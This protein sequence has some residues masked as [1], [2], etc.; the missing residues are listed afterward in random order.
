MGG[1]TSRNKGKRGE[2]EIIELLQPVVDYAY[3]SLQQR[4]VACGQPP[5]LQRNSLQS[6]GGGC[7]L[8]NMP[9]FAIEV[10]YVEQQN[11]ANIKAWWEQACEQ[12]GDD[13][14]PVLIYRRNHEDW[15]VMMRG[16]IGNHRIKAQPCVATTDMESFQWLIVNTIQ[17][18]LTEAP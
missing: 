16:S 1:L 4:G 18:H 12:A 17:K 14:Q 8:H 3:E 13:K 2:R 7:D 6:D 15:K 10:K 9:H 5:K 11:P